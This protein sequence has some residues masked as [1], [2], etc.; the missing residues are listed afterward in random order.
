MTFH[1]RTSFARLFGRATLTLAAVLAAPAVFSQSPAKPDDWPKGPITF[2]APFSAGGGGDTMTRLYANQIGKV[3]GVGFIVDNKPGAGGNIG[4]A[5]VARATPDGNTLIFG[6]MGT[7]GTNHAL[8]K[9]TG[10]SV[11]DFDPVAL[12]GSVGL[13]LVVNPGSP[14][15][16]VQDIIDHAKK[17]PGGLSCASGGNGTVSHLAC[18]LLQQMTG[19][20]VTHVPYRSSSS[21]YVDMMSDRVSFM[22]DVLTPLTPHI[23]SGKLRAV[24]TSMKQR[25]GALPDTPTIAETVPGYEIFSWDGLFAP[26]G[27]PPARLDKLHAA[28]GTALSDPEFRQTMAERGIMLNTM[29]RKEFAEF[30]KKEAVRM[31]DVVRK[32]GVT[33]D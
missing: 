24:G 1:P 18:A 23:K 21:A 9:S 30:V 33:L 28:V 11:S 7:M 8:Y 25:I 32:I 4:T 31:G 22:I 13:A 16:T 2:V 20:Q 6:T 27:T 19:I 29:P 10:Y 12:F 3:M 5:A 14:Y 26:K 15:R 17:N